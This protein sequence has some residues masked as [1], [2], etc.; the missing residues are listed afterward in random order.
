K[1]TDRDTG[2]PIR[3][4]NVRI[5]FSPKRGPNEPAP[6]LPS[7]LID[8][9]Q[10]FNSETGT[11]KLADLVA[12]MPLQVMIDAEGYERKVL[13]RVVVT[14]NDEAEEVEFEMERVDPA[15]LRNYAGRLLDAQGKPI[16]GAQLRLIVAG[17][18]KP[19]QRTQFP[20]NWQMISTGQISQQS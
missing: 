20:F 14:R 19:G 2:K 7:D 16:A 15:T 4:F 11:F 5:T 12:R 3:S 9:G 6:G 10:A 17:P 8:P 1:V 18:R 13:E